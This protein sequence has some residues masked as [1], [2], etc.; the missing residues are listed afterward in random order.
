MSVLDHDALQAS[1][2]ADLH[3]LASE[4]SID[5][6]RRLRRAELIEAILAKQEGRAPEPVAEAAPK[7]TVAEAPEATDE[8]E[9][10]TV[11]DAEDEDRDEPEAAERE[12]AAAESLALGLI[13]RD[14]AESLAL[15]SFIGHM[16]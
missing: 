4:L 11:P 3:A 15:N 7:E 16:A 6:F 10:D 8:G 14:L 1:P 12:S 2:L 13:P 5:G 9:A